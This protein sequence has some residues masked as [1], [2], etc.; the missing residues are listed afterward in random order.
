[1]ATSRTSYLCVVTTASD[2]YTGIKTVHDPLTL[3]QK[4]TIQDTRP[5]KGTVW[6]WIGNTGIEIP[7]D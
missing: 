3:H 4:N 1:M 5:N 7:L 2:S 6:D